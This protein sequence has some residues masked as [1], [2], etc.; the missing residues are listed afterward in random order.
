MELESRD[1]QDRAIP[2]H[3]ICL[4]TGLRVGRPPAWERRLTRRVDNSGAPP[5]RHPTVHA[6]AFW[7]GALR[8]VGVWHTAWSINWVSHIWGCRNYATPDASRN[9]PLIGLINRR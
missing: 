4:G 1:G 7:G 3:P 9:N 5:S 6:N 2:L 8:T